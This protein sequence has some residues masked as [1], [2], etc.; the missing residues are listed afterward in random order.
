MIC[1]V[2]FDGTLVKNDFFLEIFFRTLIERP[3]FL[4]KILYIKKLSLIEI[5]Q[6]LLLNHQIE[7]NLSGLMNQLVLDWITLNKHKYSEIYLVSATPDFFIKRVLKNQP[8]FDEIYG[9]T[10]INLKGVNKLNFILDK[11]GEDFAYL[12]D[13]SA[14]IPIFKKSKEAYKVTKNKILNVKSIYQIN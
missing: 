6:E 7:Y 8:E 11:W 10:E 14:D 12:G 9:S 2:D 5:K 4:F 1:V 13:S 3:F